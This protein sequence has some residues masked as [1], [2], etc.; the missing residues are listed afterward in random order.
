MAKNQFILLMYKLQEKFFIYGHHNTHNIPKL[1]K[2]YCA[3][4]EA[5][6][7]KHSALFLKDFGKCF[8]PASS[9]IP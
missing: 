1:I 6:H 3:F 4:Y 5:F 8:L 9:Q 7:Y 2:V